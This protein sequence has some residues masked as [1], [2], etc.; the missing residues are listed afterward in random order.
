MLR[1]FNG[2]LT[3]PLFLLQPKAQLA[4]AKS[5]QDAGWNSFFVKLS[6]KAESVG[7]EL[8][9]IDPRGTSQ[10]CLCGAPCRRS[11]R[12]VG[13]SECSACGSCRLLAMSSVLR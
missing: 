7:R 11:S 3:C 6:Y 9:K 10:T 13:T 5:V 12:I 8:V 2:T 4:L 1:I